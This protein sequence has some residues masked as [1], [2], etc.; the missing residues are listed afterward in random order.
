MWGLKELNIDTTDN[1]VS[2]KFRVV[3]DFRVEYP[4]LVRADYHNS[5]DGGAWTFV[6]S[7]EVLDK[8]QAQGE[9][10]TFTKVNSYLYACS[11]LHFLF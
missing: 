11:S 2:R 3:S 4:T 1:L 8:I 6:P 9:K 10:G 5:Y 7:M